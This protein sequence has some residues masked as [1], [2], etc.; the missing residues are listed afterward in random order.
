MNGVMI[1]RLA[2]LMD[3]LTD[4]TRKEAIPGYQT[5]MIRRFACTL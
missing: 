1:R 2:S 3:Y 5:K 4:Y